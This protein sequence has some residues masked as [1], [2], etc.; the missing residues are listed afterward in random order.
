MYKAIRFQ[1]LKRVSYC[2]EIA[3]AQLIK[4]VLVNEEVGHS[5]INPCIGVISLCHAC[6]HFKSKLS[7]YLGDQV[8]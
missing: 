5:I 7:I 4:F 1:L 2:S 8:Q 3:V 6:E